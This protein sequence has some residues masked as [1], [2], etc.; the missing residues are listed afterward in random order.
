MLSSPGLVELVFLL[1]LSTAAI[2]IGAQEAVPASAGKAVLTGVAIDSLRGGYLRGA[3]IFVSGTALSAT[4]DASGRFRIEGIPAGTRVMELQHPLLD[5]LSIT[6]TTTP[7]IFSDGDASFVMLSIPSARTFVASICPAEQRARGPSVVVGTVADAESGNPSDGASVS[8]GWTDYQLSKKSIRTIPQKRVSPVSA[9]GS[10]RMCGLPD[11]LVAAVVASR[12]ND[13]TAAVEVN[14]SSLVG[15]V[16]LRLPPPFLAAAA[17]TSGVRHVKV[18]TS[19]SGRVYDADGKPSKGA[20]VAIEEDDAVA[21]TSQDGTFILGGVRPGTRRLNVRKIGYQ[22]IQ[23]AVDLRPEGITGMR[24]ALGASV[25]VLKAIVVSAA[26][27]A[28]LQRV[29]FTERKSRQSGVFLEPKDIEIRNGPSLN[30]LLE[31]VQLLK[32]SCARYFIDGFLQP[33]NPEEYLSGAEIG[34]VEVY[35]ASFVPAE[36]ISF[37]RGN[38][39]CASVVIWTKWKIGPR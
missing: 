24:V 28:G 2:P 5:S 21:M 32:R 18:T 39:P 37:S 10:F 33:G 1:G 35:S 25:A 7:K 36:F 22:P 3:S 31:K 16:S 29:G 17:D 30:I 27:D 14:L 13:S 11:D 19:I 20:R 26:R 34:A 6:L 4:T 38:S 23:T 15:I 9:A 12:G 8:V